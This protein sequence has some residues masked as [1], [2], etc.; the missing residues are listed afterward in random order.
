[1]LRDEARDR[2]IPESTIILVHIDRWSSGPL[3]LIPTDVDEA[4]ECRLRE[5]LLLPLC[6][7]EARLCRLAIA[8]QSS[9]R[10]LSGYSS[11]ARLRA[12]SRKLRH[13]LQCFL[14]DCRG[15]LVRAECRKHIVASRRI[16]DRRIAGVDAVQR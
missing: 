9:L 13:I 11:G 3:R 14:G 1:M 10:I 15:V 4:I 8:G 6:S 16:K 5:R 2:T 7:M 12:S